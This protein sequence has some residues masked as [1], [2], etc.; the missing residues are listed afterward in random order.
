VESKSAWGDDTKVR[1]LSGS[2]SSGDVRTLNNFELD[3]IF[4]AVEGGESD[5]LQK[6]SPAIIVKTVWQCCDPKA[7]AQAS[8]IIRSTLH[9]FFGLS[10][11]IDSR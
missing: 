6:S 11:R 4:K 3:A 1:K 9:K 10:R 7:D 8:S 5:G 2:R